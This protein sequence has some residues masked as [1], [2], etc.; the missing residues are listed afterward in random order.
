[1]MFDHMAQPTMQRSHGKAMVRF[2]LRGDQ[3]RLRDLAQSGSA[4]AMLPRVWGHVPEVV[5]LNTSGGLTGGDALS[6]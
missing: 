3:T 4:K 1:M 2:A 6:Y 5:F